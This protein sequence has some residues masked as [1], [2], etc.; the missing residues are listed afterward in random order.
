[1]TPTDARILRELSA[2]LRKFSEL[3][4]PAALGRHSVNTESIKRELAIDDLDI[5]VSVGNLRRMAC[6]EAVHFGDTY[7]PSPPGE[8][9]ITEKDTLGLNVHSASIFQRPDVIFLTPL[10]AAFV[11]A[12]MTPLPQKR[13]NTRQNG[14]AGDKRE[15]KPKD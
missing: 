6:V 11:Q 15:A 3:E 14:R 1:M 7:R 13:P 10:G 2:S 5:L 9:H 8:A 12:C 4:D